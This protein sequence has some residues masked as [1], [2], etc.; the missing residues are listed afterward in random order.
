MITDLFRKTVL[1][2]LSVAFFIPAT[3]AQDT[4]TLTLKHALNYALAHYTDAR[5][6]KLDITNSQY[7]VD[8]VRARALPQISGSGALNYNPL[9][10]MSALP[11]ELN[12]VNPGQTLLVAFGQKWN[13]NVG[14]SLTQN[15]F[16]Q[17][18]F[19]GLKA[20]KTTKEFYQLNAQLTEEQVLEKVATA[21]Y[22]VLVQRQQITTTDSNIH[23]TQKVRSVIAGQFENGLGKKIDVDRLDV[24]LSNLQSQRQQQLNAV[25]QYENQL[26]FFIGMPIGTAIT[27]PDMES[28]T[29]DVFTIDLPDTIATDNRT[30]V[31]VLSKQQE[32]LKQKRQSILAEYYPSLSLSGNYSYQGLA[33]DFPIFKG[34]SKGANW[35]DVSTVGLNLKVPIFNGNG[36]RAR[37]RQVDIEIGKLKEDMYA[38][39]QTLNLDYDNAK[40]QIKNS[41]IILNSQQKNIELAQKVMDNTQNNYQQGLATLTDLLDA[42][43][44]LYD[45]QNTYT[46][47]LLD[48]RLA[49][50]KLIKSKGQLRT[51]LN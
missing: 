11:G 12:P 41:I 6:A 32:L 40:T 19:V 3:K 20:A 44:A 48:Y 39:T 18:V 8:E 45:A 25:A 35:F 1:C 29:V 22:Q 36:T 13:A 37:T 15:L 43:T 21:Y 28:K 23:T 31:L 49:E 17:S 5:K 46:V 16:D 42:Q 26:K 51:L 24:K 30:N 7:Q 38:T 27:I 4:E 2:L 47:S 9:L 34:A 33:N 10:Q 50:V 14:V